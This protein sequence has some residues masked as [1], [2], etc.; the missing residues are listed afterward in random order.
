[1]TTATG[2]T[3]GTRGRGDPG[4]QFERDGFVVVS[5]LFRP[6]E[7]AA[8]KREVQ[9]IVAQATEEAR[10]RGEARPRFLETGVLVGLATCSPY[11]RDLV[12]DGRLLD[13]LEPI[14]GPDILFWSDKAVFKTEET[15]LA[16]PWHQDWAYWRGIHKIT[17]WVALDDADEANGCLKLLRGSHRA[18][19]VHDAAVPRGEGFGHRVDAGQVPPEAVV[20]APVRAG[21][22]VIFHDLLLHASCPNTSGRDRWAWLP[23]YKDAQAQDLE[24]PAMTAA[25]V[26]R[27]TGRSE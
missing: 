14:I 26:V 19:V 5:D 15:T 25:A 10:S 27:G 2:A 22:A 6:Q 1:M 20:T 9:R 13:R 8:I 23:T 17:V 21:G 7:A 4:A 12:R 24:Y 11:F 18:A 3:G 16:T